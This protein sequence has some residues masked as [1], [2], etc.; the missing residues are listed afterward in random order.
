MKKR[1]INELLDSII[2]FSGIEKHID[3]PVKRYS[4][5]M[6]VRLA[7]AVAAH[8][9]CDI[10]I[11]DE[12]L[13]VGDAE[14]QKKALGKMYDLSTGQGKT[15]LFVSHNMRAVEDLCNCGIIIESGKIIDTSG[16]IQKITS[17]YYKK[18]LNNANSIRWNNN[19]SFNELSYTPLSLEILEEDGSTIDSC[20]Y[21]DKNYIVKLVFNAKEINPNL[22]FYFI[23][24]SINNTREALFYTC[25]QDYKKDYK[26]VIGINTF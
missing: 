24:S 22:I 3:T 19:G 5:G 23:F 26:Q 7:F 4:S 11:A 16:N 12:V 8:L 13:A 14:F 6:Y 18:Y 10:L 1:R 25:P 20:I 9:D 21:A 17:N 15:V 2:G